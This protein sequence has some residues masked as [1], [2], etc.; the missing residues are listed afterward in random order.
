MSCSNFTP[1]ATPL[2][3]DFAWVRFARFHMLVIPIWNCSST[4]WNFGQFRIMKLRTI[5]GTI[6]E[7]SPLS[8]KQPSTSTDYFNL[9]AY[10]YSHFIYTH[11]WLWIKRARFIWKTLYFALKLNPI[12]AWMQKLFFRRSLVQMIMVIWGK[13]GSSI[14]E[15]NLQSYALHIRW[16]HA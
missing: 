3:W 10:I 15:Y 4:L 8:L 14:V 1:T 13:Q 16:I 7:I 2:L 11:I 12:S 9:F 5:L 6:F